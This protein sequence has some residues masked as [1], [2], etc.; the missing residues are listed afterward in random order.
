M[1][2][3]RRKPAGAPP[4][5]P[6]QPSRLGAALDDPMRSVYMLAVLYTVTLEAMQSRRGPGSAAE[7]T[8]TTA[9]GRGRRRAR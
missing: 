2:G 7:G 3:R 1:A 6:E 8:A 5:G 4:G 9:A